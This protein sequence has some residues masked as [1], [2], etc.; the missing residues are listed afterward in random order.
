[1]GLAAKY[2]FISGRAR[3]D[4]SPLASL[5]Y[6]VDGGEW[7]MLSPAD[8]ICDDLVEAFTLK[9][10]ALAPGPH[11][12][13]VRAWDGADNVGVGVHHRPRPDAKAEVKNMSDPVADDTAGLPPA[14]EVIQIEV[15]LLQNFCEILFCPE[16]REAAIVDPAFEVDRLLHEALRQNL[17]VKLALITHTHHDHIDG[18][19][20]LCDKTGAAVV[21]NPREAAA[22]RAPGRTLIDADGRSGHRDRAARRTRAADA[23]AHRRRNL[24]PG[25]RVRGDGRRPLRGRLRPHRLHGR[26]H[27]ADVEQPAAAGAPARGDAGLP[28]SRLRRDAHLDHRPRAAD[29][30]VFALR[31]LRRVPRDA[32]PQARIDRGDCGSDLSGF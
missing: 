14:P 11:A 22:V 6:A 8:G 32:G 27:G 20:E 23:R 30:S 18:V 28:R 9:L 1:M 2:P 15:G 4:Q 5:E 10:P 17:N 3:D 29:Q 26:R 16:T 12:V 21:V 13:T 25:R 19:A 31:E 7:Q 24:L